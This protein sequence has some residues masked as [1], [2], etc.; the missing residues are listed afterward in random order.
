MNKYEQKYVS[1]NEENL[2][3]HY[4]CENQIYEKKIS[5]DILDS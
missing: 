1:Q 3:F 2:V 4:W 5:F